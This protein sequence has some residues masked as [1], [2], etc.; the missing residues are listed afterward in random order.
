MSAANECTK[1]IYC[2]Q[3]RTGKGKHQ[4]VNGILLPSEVKANNLRHLQVNFVT[5]TDDVFVVTYPKC[6]TTWMQQIVKLIWNKGKEDGRDIDE[7]FPWAEMISTD[8]A[9]VSLT[10]CHVHVSAH[11]AAFVRFVYSRAEVQSVR[12][13]LYWKPWILGRGL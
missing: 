8:T 9:A 11:R 13:F 10:A 6:G 2:Q 3:V 4:I 5:R 12:R 1:K 7:V